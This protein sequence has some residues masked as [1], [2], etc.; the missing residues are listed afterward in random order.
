L[1]FFNH[2]FWLVADTKT[3]RTG[4]NLSLTFADALW[5]P[6]NGNNR[7]RGKNNL[8]AIRLCQIEKIIVVCYS[9]QRGKSRRG[10][11]EGARTDKQK[12]V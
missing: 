2:I 7:N 9:R 3:H 4:Y 12:L 6:P 10:E 8:F 1:Q 11:R 5:R